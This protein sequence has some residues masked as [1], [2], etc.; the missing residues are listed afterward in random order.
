M[1][2]AKW[3]GIWIELKSVFLQL[4]ELIHFVKNSRFLHYEAVVSTMKLCSVLSLGDRPWHPRREER[5][6]SVTRH[7]VTWWPGGPHVE[8]STPMTT[9]CCQVN[10]V[11]SLTYKNVRQM[12]YFRIT[13]SVLDLNGKLSSYSRLDDASNRFWLRGH[14]DSSWSW[15]SY[16]WWGKIYLLYSDKYAND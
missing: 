14:Y 5:S 4:N 9:N 7:R 13:P 11:K 6:L 12:N 1:S 10:N 2:S 8:I 16:R 15:P 3:V